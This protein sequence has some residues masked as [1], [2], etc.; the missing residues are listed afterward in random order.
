MCVDDALEID[1]T[2]IYVLL[3]NRKNSDGYKIKN[4][5]RE[6]IGNGLVRDGKAFSASSYSGG[7]AGSTTIA[8]LVLSSITLL[9]NWPY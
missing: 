1:S 2:R 9:N 3:Q 7:F 8:S 4:P 6:T 5:S